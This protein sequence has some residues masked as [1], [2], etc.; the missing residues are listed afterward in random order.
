MNDRLN[1]CKHIGMSLCRG[2][3]ALVIG[4]CIVATAHAAT[5]Q[6]TFASPD[7]AAAELVSAVKAHDADGILAIL[8]ADADRWVRSGDP[9]ADRTA[10]DRFVTMYEEKHAI[11]SVLGGTRAVLT[12]GS[13]DWPFAFPIAKSKSGWRFDTA[14]GK[15]ELLARRIGENELAVINVM[16]AIVDA[17]R[18]YASA[19]RNSDG[20]REY[21][22]AFV[23]TPGKKDGLYWPTAAGEPVSPLGGLVAA[24]TGEGYGDAAGKPY[25][26]Y[27]FRMLKGQGKN[28]PGGGFD[29]TVKGHTIGGFAAI[30][31][32]ARYGNSGIMTFIV[33]HAGVVYQKDL[34]ADTTKL[35]RAITRFD[36]GPGWVAVQVD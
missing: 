31:Y 11:A 14:A 25:H 2:M 24:A 30:A 27:Y 19:D 29:Y 16:L 10:A 1:D 26:G 15:R 3:L 4:V 5:A 8:G 32:P 17:Q 22:R 23:S 28:A 9:V 20:V 6:R 33:S 7:Q 35:A 36:P 18:D 34:G 12:I 13:D 21:A